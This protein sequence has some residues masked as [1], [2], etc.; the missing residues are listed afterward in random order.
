[1]DH[2]DRLR[3]LDQQLRALLRGDDDRLADP[4]FPFGRESGR[5]RKAGDQRGAG[6]PAAKNGTA[7]NGPPTCAG[8]ATPS[9]RLLPAFRLLILIRMLFSNSTKSMPGM[10]G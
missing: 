2:R 4:R 1:A 5:E 9:A 10:R 6:D 3:H 8:A 7:H